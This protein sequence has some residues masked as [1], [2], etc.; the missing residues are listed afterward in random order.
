MR[1]GLLKTAGLGRLKTA[2]SDY[3]KPDPLV[4]FWNRRRIQAPSNYANIKDYF[5]VFLTHRELVDKRCEHLTEEKIKP[6]PL[7]RLSTTPF[8]AI[9]QVRSDRTGCSRACRR[10][11]GDQRRSGLFHNS[12]IRFPLIVER[13]LNYEN[14][15]PIHAT[16]APLLRSAEQ[17]PAQRCLPLRARRP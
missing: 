8:L 4:R 12:W 6:P 3:K 11:Q 1:L 14:R 5:V 10:S 7:L 2:D 17:A 9:I 16:G 13:A 15:A